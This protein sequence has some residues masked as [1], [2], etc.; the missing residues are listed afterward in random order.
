MK[1]ILVTGG[2]GFVGSNLV[3]ELIKNADY[4]VVVCDEF[5]VGDKWRNLS[6]HPAHE[7]I[8]H[9]E[10]FPWLDENRESLEVIYHLGSLSSTTEDNIDFI[11]KNNF[12]L[13]VKLWRWCNKHNIRFI[14]ASAAATYG[15]GSNGFDDRMDLPYL[16]SLT[17]LSGYGWSKHLFDTHVANSIAKSSA[18]VPQWVGLKIFN[19]YGANEYHKGNQKSVVAQIALHAIEHSSIKLFRSYN[20]DY[21]DG[22]QLRDMVYIKDVVKVLIWFLNNKNISGLF[23]LG[24]GKASSFNE[25]AKAIFM[26]LGHDAK[27]SYIDMPPPLMKKYQYYTEAKMDKLRSVGCN[28]QFASLQEGVKDYMQNYLLKEDPYI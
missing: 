27:I 25:M 15:S 28:H 23:N 21:P 19:A 16:Y 12:S 7:I 4:N 17:P 14:Y 3:A 20:P 2:G 9:S 11:L 10:L 1:N 24:S 8:S 26:A 22:G 18:Q 5:G 13:S 6:K